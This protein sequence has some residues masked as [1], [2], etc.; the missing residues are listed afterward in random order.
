MNRMIRKPERSGMTAFRVGNI[1]KSNEKKSKRRD[2]VGKETEKI[3][4][5]L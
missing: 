4:F 5:S 1:G 3:K 2:F